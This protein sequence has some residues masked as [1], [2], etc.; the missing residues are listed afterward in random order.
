MEGGE[1]LLNLSN[2]DTIS[3]HLA[4][5]MVDLDYRSTVG[6]SQP[7]RYPCGMRISHS[8]CLSPFFTRL[9][10][11]WYILWASWILTGIWT[12]LAPEGSA[13]FWYWASC[14]PPADCGQTTWVKVKIPWLGWFSLT[15]HTCGTSFRLLFK[16]S[17]TSL[18]YMPWLFLAS[19]YWCVYL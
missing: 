11:D 4:I 5:I 8:W 19:H 17:A 15:S 7:I 13:R 3:S 18:W 2:L 9:L 6:L 10:W 14:W 16:V 12:C 1:D